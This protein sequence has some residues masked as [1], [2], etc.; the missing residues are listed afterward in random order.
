[1]TRISLL[2]VSLALFFA[3]VGLR[4]EEKA[5]SGATTRE[6]GVVERTEKAVVRGAK[7]TANGIDRGI[8]AAGK[9][10]AR[11]ITATTEF[12]EKGAKATVRGV[13][14]GARATGEFID[15]G[16]TATASAFDK[17]GKKLETKQA[18]APVEERR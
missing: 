7:A 6:P 13:E 11:G 18:P 17:A 4:A 12:V 14:R 10:V 16:V 5:A 8:D 15:R 9:G 1:M 2:A 3:S